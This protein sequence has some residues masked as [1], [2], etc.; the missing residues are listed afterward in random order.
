METTARRSM[1]TEDVWEAFRRE[2][3]ISIRGCSTDGWIASWDGYPDAGCH[4]PA[5]GSTPELAIAVAL[6]VEL[7]PDPP[8]ILIS[9]PQLGERCKCRRHRYGKDWNGKP[10]W[11]ENT[12]Y[13][14]AGPWLATSAKFCSD[15]GE[16]LRQLPGAQRGGEQ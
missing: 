14:Q 12:S 15:C 7:S 1:T 16:A 13:E 9:T 8:D 3:H 10:G 5:W 6:G 4:S 11:A 2:T